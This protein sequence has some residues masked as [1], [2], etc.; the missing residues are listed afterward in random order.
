M[1]RKRGFSLT[2]IIISMALIVTVSAVGFLACTV[3]LRIGANGNRE[4]NGYADAE[5]L[6]LSLDR[7]FGSIGGDKERKDDFMSAFT[8]ELEWYFGA[9]GLSEL[10]KEQDLRGEPWTVDA[11]EG[12]ETHVSVYYYGV[13]NGLESYAYSVTVHGKAC[14]TI[15]ALN[16]RTGTFYTTVSVYRSGDERPYYERRELYE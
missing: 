10:V 3:A 7:A 13:D 9:E 11:P 8:D 2:E 1:R 12:G 4:M 16:I 5:M 6:R 15:L 14:R